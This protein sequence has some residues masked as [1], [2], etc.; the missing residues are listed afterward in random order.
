MEEEGYRIQAR[1]VKALAQR[2]S[3]QKFA[4]RFH[5]WSGLRPPTVVKPR[6]TGGVDSGW[7]VPREGHMRSPVSQNRVLMRFRA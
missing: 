2:A 7:I 1:M 5:L 4:L 6:G 3:L